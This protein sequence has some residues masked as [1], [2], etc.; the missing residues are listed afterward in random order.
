LLYKCTKFAQNGIVGVTINYRLGIEGFLYLKDEVPNRGMLDQIC[1]L[2]WIRDHIHLFGGDPQKVTVA[3]ESAGGMSVGTLLVMPKA[4]GLFQRAILQ[5]GAAHHTISLTTAQKVTQVF[6]QVSGL[7]ATRSALSHIPRTKF[8]DIQ[9]EVA[10]VIGTMPDYPRELRKNFMP[11]EPVVD[12]DIIPDYP[13]KIF[14]SDKAF[15]VDILSGSNSEEWN[16][17]L[18]P[19]KLLGKV[20]DEIFKNLTLWGDPEE[21]K[22]VYRQ[23]YPTADL[24][25]LYGAVWTDTFYR[26]PAIR[27]AESNVRKKKH[28]TFVYIFSWPSPVWGGAGHAT[29]LPFVF[30]TFAESESEML[31]GKNPPVELADRIHKAWVDF[32]REGNPGWPEYDLKDRTVMNFNVESKVVKDPFPLTRKFWHAKL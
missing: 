18:V 1:A 21:L 11:F 9:R 6:E 17:L 16:F 28:K 32:T 25:Q 30:H 31:I 26:I 23:E 13:Y 24:S 3:G 12:G 8:T 15:D 22:T 29:D 2:E 20:N 14:E 4:K 7:S 27:V 5:S 19:T 10:K